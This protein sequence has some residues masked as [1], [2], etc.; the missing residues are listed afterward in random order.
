MAHDFP[1]SSFW[2]RMAPVVKAD[3]STSSWNGL[4]ISG[5]CRAGSVS[6]VEMSLSS[7]LQ[8]SGVHWKGVPFLSNWVK[9][10]AML[11]KLGIKGHW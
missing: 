3:A 10:R 9:G 4:V 1:L 7:A 8:H 2:E 5:C 11:A 6:T